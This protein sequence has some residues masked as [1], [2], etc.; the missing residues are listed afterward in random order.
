MAFQLAPDNRNQPDEVLLDDLRTASSKLGGRKL[1]REAYAQIGRFAAATIAG[2][3]GGWGKA[4][5]KAGLVPPR[6]FSVSRD[7]CVKDL[8]RVAAEL[9]I[10]TLTVAVYRKFGRYSEKPFEHHFTG[11]V[12]AL[13][14]AG[15]SVSDQYHSRSS[16]EDLFENL[17]AVWQRLGRQ[18][19][20]ND[21]VP[22]LSRF[23]AHSYKRRFGGFR[24]ALEAFVAASHDSVADLPEASDSPDPNAQSALPAVA[25]RAG[26]RSVG[27]RLRYLVLKRDRFCCRACGRSPANEPGTLLHIDHVVPW[28]LGGPTTEANLQTLC[29]RCNIGKGAA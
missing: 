19:T 7:D 20:V 16:N 9:G 12:D 23:S 24:R 22:P 6:N 2:R 25:P 15:L 17:E 26:A 14:A 29:D 11:W 3:F 18:P 27:W 4:L 13:H 10:T 21:M 8:Q 1:S 5:V 28:S